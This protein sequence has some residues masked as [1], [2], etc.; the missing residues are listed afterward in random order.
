[1]KAFLGL[2]YSLKNVVF[3]D[4]SAYVKADFVLSSVKLAHSSGTWILNKKTVYYVVSSGLIPVP[5]WEIFLNNGGLAKYL[6]KANAYDLKL[7]R[8]E[9]MI[10]GDSRVGG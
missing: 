4:V 3:G 8:L 7:N 2:G 1:M 6:V 10:E 5:S 9:L